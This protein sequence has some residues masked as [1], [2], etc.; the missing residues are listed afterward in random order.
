M[1]EL[2]LLI[3]SPGGFIDPGMAMYNF[4]R[5]IPVPV[6]TY[7]YGNVDS[8]A[9]VVYCAGKRRLA[10]PQCRFLIHGVTWTFSQPAT[11]TEQQLREMLGNVAAMKKN[12]ADV[13]AATS[14]QPV[15]KV[16][17]D[18]SSSLT[19]QA[20]EAK[21]YGLVHDLTETLVPPGADLIGIR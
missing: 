20:A 8:V 19:L 12:I 13:I 6:T 9:T 18:M 21:T 15:A 4:L 5:G 2:H 1:T 17:A 11:L 7:N 3:A 10:T 16:E 14:G